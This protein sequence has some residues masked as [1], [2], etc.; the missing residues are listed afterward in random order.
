MNRVRRAS[1]AVVLTILVAVFVPPCVVSQ[2]TDAGGGVTPYLHV[3]IQSLGVAGVEGEATIAWPLATDVVGTPIVGAG[4]DQFAEL[5]AI[6][7]TGGTTF[8]PGTRVGWRVEGRLLSTDADGVRAELRWKRSVLDA[9]VV[10]ASEF[11]RESNLRLVEGRRQVLDLVRPPTG[12]TPDCEG[13]VVE[14]WVEFR[15]ADQ[16]AKSVLDYEVWLVHHEGDGREVVDRTAGRGLQGKSLEYTFRRL[17]YT[18]DGIGDPLGEVE[19]DL[20]GSVKGRVR[21]DGRIDLS[22][23]AS[24]LVMKAGLGGGESGSKQ[25]TVSDGETLEFELPPHRLRGRGFEA[26][27]TSIRVTVRRLS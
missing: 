12:V 14:A 1:C 18:A 9:T 13:V 23:N 4:T 10:D 20:S 24:R 16:V 3:S 22:V 26:Q 19:V 2:G 15:E 11:E 25:A 7:S 8:L 6:Y 21:P 17:R 27:R 5:C